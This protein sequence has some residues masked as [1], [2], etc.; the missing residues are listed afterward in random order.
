MLIV[1][2]KCI[3]SEIIVNDVHYHKYFRRHYLQISCQSVSVPARW[4]QTVL[5]CAFLNSEWRPI[6]SGT[7]LFSIL[8]V[9]SLPFGH[10]F[11]D[12]R[13]QKL[14]DDHPW[15][16]GGRSS[17][18]DRINITGLDD[19]C[20]QKKTL[21]GILI[22]GANCGPLLKYS[23]FFNMKAHHRSLCINKWLRY[24]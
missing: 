1:I 5:S 21:A 16:R 11:P 15:G 17:G 3:S 19:W 20:R 7:R 14:S 24:S 23:T 2:P 22:V 10:R 8:R 4:H 18:I 12:F 13:Q 6:L 9:L